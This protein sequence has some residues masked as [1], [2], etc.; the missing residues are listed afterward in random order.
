MLQTRKNLNFFQAIYHET[1]EQ[2]QKEL[3][4]SK[5]LLFQTISK[6]SSLQLKWKNEAASRNRQIQELT[7]SLLLLE[8]QLQREKKK[9]Q[10]QSFEQTKIIKALKI[11]NRK[12]SAFSEGQIQTI[13]S[14]NKPSP[15]NSENPRQKILRLGNCSFNE[16]RMRKSKPNPKS[17]SIG[18]DSSS[19]SGSSEEIETEKI[20][21]WSRARLEKGIII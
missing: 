4:S 17:G 2:L 13:Y 21:K 9:A 16:T 1:N 15:I 20:T 5:A 3:R 7:S 10:L 8:S 19:S 12:L 14:A 11:E 18:S 6:F